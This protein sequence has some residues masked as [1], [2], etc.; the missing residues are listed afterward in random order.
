MRLAAAVHA[1]AALLGRETCDRANRT[2]LRVC[3]ECRNR[4]D[5]RA[6]LLPVAI[7]APGPNAVKTANPV[8]IAA[9]SGRNRRTSPFLRRRVG[10][11]P[12]RDPRIGLECGY[13]RKFRPHRRPKW[14]ES[15]DF[16]VSRRLSLAFSQVAIR[17]PGLNAVTTADSRWCKKK[18]PICAFAAWANYAVASALYRKDVG[19]PRHVE[20]F[21][22][23][24]ARMQQAQRS[25][26]CRHQLQG[27]Y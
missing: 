20:D 6:S 17:A 3:F 9:R 5:G 18:S 27:G 19:K 12:G 10:V 26:T 2:A 24:I 21:N 22:H 23:V 16:A 14:T 11:F 1:Q 15:T 4:V 8:H 25:S 7:R 13:S